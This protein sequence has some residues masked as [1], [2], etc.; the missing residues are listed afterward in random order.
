MDA[1]ADRYKSYSNT[2]LVG[3]L[4]NSDDYQPEALAA[5]QAELRGRNLSEQTILDARQEN[6][7]VQQAKQQSHARVAQASHQAKSWWP[8]SSTC[9][10]PSKVP[11]RRRSAGHAG[12]VLPLY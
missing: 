2:A 12:L 8:L 11:R 5:A 3:M 4:D 9:S 1:F 10:I 7:I 6:L